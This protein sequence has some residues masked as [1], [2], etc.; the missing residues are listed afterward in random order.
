MEKHPNYFTIKNIAG[1]EEKVFFQIDQDIE[2]TLEKWASQ[3]P[4]MIKNNH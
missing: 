3:N 4:S 2:P 1:E